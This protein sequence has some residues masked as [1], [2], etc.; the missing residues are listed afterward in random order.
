MQERDQK[1]VSDVIKEE[2]NK[3]ETKVIKITNKSHL[4]CPL[5]QQVETMLTSRDLAQKRNFVGNLGNSNNDSQKYI[6][7]ME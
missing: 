4:T 7:R 1:I 6:T 5:P 3:I 2:D